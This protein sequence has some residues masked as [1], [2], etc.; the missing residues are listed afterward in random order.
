M[1]KQAFPIYT[2][3]Q[4]EFYTHAESMDKR[5]ASLKK[6]K[7]AKTSPERSPFTFAKATS[8]DQ[9]HPE[10]NEDYVLTDR[11]SGL[12]VICD[13]VGCVSGAG[14]AA[15]IA[16]RAVSTSWKGMLTQCAA[17]PS[18]STVP[19]RD[20]E[21]AVQQLLEEAN[22]AVLALEKRLAQK[23][24]E[25]QSAEKK[26]GAAT[27]IALALFYPHHTGYLMVY[28]HIGDSRIYL[29]RKDAAIQRLTVDD[30]YFPWI[31]NK[32]ELSEQD[33][34]RI[35]QA[36][37]AD[38]LSEADREHFEKRNKISQSLG[39]EPI[40]LH[41]GQLVLCPGDRIL[42]STDGIHDNL[43]D[44]E[45]EVVLRTGARTT[46]AKALVQQALTRSQQ[47]ET[48]HIRAKTDDMSAI[49]ITCHFSPASK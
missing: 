48:V 6:H 8:P 2:L 25:E 46:V 31:V 3:Y 49:V 35:D 34:W 1:R 16:A 28:A 19:A 7:S 9:K 41:V 36:S 15:R 30:G 11:G 10:R 5:I 40:T 32:G 47:G 43:T 38:Q 17:T 33:A 24:Q 14:Q 39:D 13:G 23:H 37:S 12:A 4:K 26:N 20:L 22:Q 44:A 18:H 45:I 27:T 29:L 21:N 42:L